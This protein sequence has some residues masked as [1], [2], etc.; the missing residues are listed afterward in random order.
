MFLNNT[1]ISNNTLPEVFGKFFSDKV[2]NL[3]N[4]LI[5]ND[6]VYNGNRKIDSQNEFFMSG[7]EILDV[8]SSIKLK[9]C[10][11]FDRIPQRILVEGAESLIQPLTT[12]FRKIY[13]QKTIPEQWLISKIVPIHKKGAKNQIDNYRPIAN[14]CSTSKIFERLI[15]KR[16]Q[17]LELVNNADLTG[18]QQHGFKKSKSTT[19]LA[20][21][22][23]SLIARALDDDNYVLMASL[24]LSAAFDVVNINL[25]MKRLR[26]LDFADDNYTLTWSKSKLSTITLMEEKIEII[27]NGS[28]I[29]D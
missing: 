24:D 9:N 2:S 20:L 19:T 27:K 13:S 26:I 29:Q 3:T 10:E 5:I 14:L 16:I 23:Q 17:T 18:K 6:N 4:N 12:L 28:L 8:L 11:G 25:L 1:K 21:Q 7:T 15:L 22:L